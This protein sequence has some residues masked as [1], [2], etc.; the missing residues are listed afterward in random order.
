M[1]MLL[2]E[3]WSLIDLSVPSKFAFRYCTTE[4]VFW[5]P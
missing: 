1:D 5:Q 3:I 4:D 2:L